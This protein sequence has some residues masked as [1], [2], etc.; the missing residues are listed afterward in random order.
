M[1]GVYR[2]STTT[3]IVCFHPCGLVGSRG[4]DPA[5]CTAAAPTAP[6]NAD[7]LTVPGP[8]EHT[9]TT[10]IGA[11]RGVRTPFFYY[12]PYSFHWRLLI[13]ADA[14]TTTFPS[15]FLAP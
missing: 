12:S 8:S 6:A 3:H 5:H 11:Y 13:L 2:E 10:F 4:H 14:I 15:S 7:T 9:T 1:H